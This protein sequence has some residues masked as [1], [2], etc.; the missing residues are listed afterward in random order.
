MRPQVT[1]YRAFLLRVW[2]GAPGT[3]V[4]ASIRD[5]E[6]GETHAFPDLDGL[7]EW[8]RHAMPKVESMR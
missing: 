7:R 8:L 3:D 5:V 6:T 2:A 4:R 1:R